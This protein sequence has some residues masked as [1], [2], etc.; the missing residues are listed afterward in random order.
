MPADALVER[1]VKMPQRSL[2]LL[3]PQLPGGRRGCLRKDSAPEGFRKVNGF[4]DGDVYPGQS[5]R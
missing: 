2:R 3:P 5:I 4:E 1:V